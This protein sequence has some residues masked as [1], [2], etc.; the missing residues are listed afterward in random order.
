MP[1]IIVAGFLQVKYIMLL[2]EKLNNWVKKDQKMKISINKQIFYKTFN[3]LF[4]LCEI[5]SSLF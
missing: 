5:F 3:K 4:Y 1:A 2:Q